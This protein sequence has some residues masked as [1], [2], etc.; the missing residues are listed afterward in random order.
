MACCSNSLVCIIWL[1]L[2]Y[3]TRTMSACTPTFPLISGQIDRITFWIKLNLHVKIIHPYLSCPYTF[4]ICSSADINKENQTS[5]IKKPI[6]E[7]DPCIYTPLSSTF[8]WQ[9]NGLW[10]CFHAIDIT[11]SSLVY[12]CTLK[13]ACVRPILISFLVSFFAPSLSAPIHPKKA[14][15]Y[16]CCVVGLCQYIMRIWSNCK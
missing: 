5:P 10:I 2:G 15:T 13:A 4:L 8:S 3:D 16:A 9:R 14:V 1:V 7:R 11:F 12:P 6:K